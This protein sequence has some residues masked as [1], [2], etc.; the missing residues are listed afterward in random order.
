MAE[1]CGYVVRVEQLRPHTNADRLQIATFF[2]SDVIVDLSTK[3]GDIGVY[4][5]TDL[6]LSAEFCDVNN[7]VRRKD[8]NGKEVGG[9]LDPGKRNIKPI[10]LRG[11]KS[12]GLYLPIT[13]LSGFTDITTLSI[14]DHID[15]LNGKV[16][17]QKYVPY[18]STSVSG[19]GKV[20]ALKK[21][22]CPT[23]FEHED[24]EQLVHNMDAFKPG[25]EIEITVKMHGTS[26]RVGYLPLIHEK[27][28]NFLQRLFRRPVKTYTE[29][30]YIT[31]SRRV[32]LADGHQGGFYDSDDWR[33][34]MTH[35]L[36]G[37]LRKGEVVYGEIVGFQGPGGRPI[38]GEG[39]NTKIG[40]KDFVK[41]FGEITVFSYGCDPANGYEDEHPCCDLY[42][43]RMVME[44][45]DGDVV[46]YDPDFMRYRCAQMGV[47]CVPKCIRFII[48]EDREWVNTNTT[49]EY[50]KTIAENYYDGADP[51]DP[52]HIREGV[53]IRVLNRP[54]FTAYKHKNWYFKSITGIIKE[55][56]T[57]DGGDISADQMDEM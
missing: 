56:L 22:I 39:N 40:D 55:S 4:F 57:S 47:K 42:V 32:V 6:A 35:K 24:T 28:Q 37:K 14:G 51:V 5:P 50:V 52:S 9:Y 20:K 27:K 19:G 49:G 1:H 53:V 48:P 10:R 34:A 18:K 45:E 43:Y 12:D 16:I 15:T 17:C 33:F 41:K 7:L 13:C 44:N 54:K 30:G 23:F 8:E 21:N 11:E 38:M 31:G 46:E 29:Y 2:G 3:E 36:E 25:D 26:T